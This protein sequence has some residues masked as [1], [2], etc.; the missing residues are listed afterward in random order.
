MTS[1]AAQAAQSLGAQVRGAMLW[2]SILSLIALALLVATSVLGRALFGTPVTDD[3]VLA[4]GLLIVTVMLPLAS[5]QT[6]TGHIK[7]QLIGKPGSLF[8]AI[9]DRFGNLLGCLLCSGLAYAALKDSAKLYQTGEFYQGLLQL[10]IWPTKMLF[11]LGF[12]MLA[13]D[14][15]IGTIK[16]QVH[17]DEY[18]DPSLD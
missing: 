16:P 4:E 14:L 15:A 2:I 5:V 3:V 8:T 1:R 17:A 6:E 7:V 11:G 10:P 13:I 12:L 18:A 9:T